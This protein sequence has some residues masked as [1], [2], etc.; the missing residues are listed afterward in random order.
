MLYEISVQNVFEAENHV[1]AVL[2]MVAWLQDCAAEAGYR[3]NGINSH[4]SHFVDSEEALEFQ[5]DLWA[6]K[7][8]D[9]AEISQENLPTYVWSE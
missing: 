1:D 4:V 3:A 8:V 6:N 7:N 9:L 5:H 2:Q